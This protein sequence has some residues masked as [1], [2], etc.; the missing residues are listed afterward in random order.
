MM[1][2]Q[3][4][5]DQVTFVGNSQQGLAQAEQDPPDLI[6]VYL[7]TPG[8]DAFEFLK[9]V[10]KIPALAHVPVIIFGAMLP[11]Q[12]YRLVRPSGAAGYL[13]QPF[14]THALVQAR[15]AALNHLTYFP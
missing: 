15:N 6:F 14:D 7:W 11:Q 12:A 8:L 13:L 9:C 1:L 5:D 3:K 10:K 4:H 2:T